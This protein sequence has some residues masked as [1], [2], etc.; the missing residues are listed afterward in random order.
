MRLTVLIL[1][2]FPFSVNAQILEY[3]PYSDSVEISIAERLTVDSAFYFISNELEFIDFD[4]CNE[5]S[6]RA[7]LMAAIL[8]NRFPSLKSAKVWLFA[9]FKRASMEEKYKYKKNSYLVLNDDCSSWGYHVAPVVI[10]ENKG[11]ADT[12]VI[13]PTTQK[14]AVKLNK[15]AFR[16]I[17]DEGKALIAVKDKKYYLFP[18]NDSKKFED[19]KKS[20]IDDDKSLLDDD[21]SKS[22]EKILISNR[23]IYDQG[24][25][26]GEIK[27][28]KKLLNVD[29]N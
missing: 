9:D 1:F 2:L 4:D 29:G 15:W 11:G 8:E 18:D 28:L 13:D 16:L 6:S 17:P 3:S 25:L 23:R 12:I 24:I 26:M 19:M 21:Y 14:T 27:K 10:I 5:C 7:H 20:W 22:I